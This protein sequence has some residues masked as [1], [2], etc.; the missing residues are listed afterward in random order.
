MDGPSKS[1]SASP[2]MPMFESFRSELDE[3]HD[4]R[5]RVIKASRDITAASKKII[6]S[7][8]RVRNLGQPIPPGIQKANTQYWKSIETQYES[9]SRDLQGLNTHRYGR[10][11]TGGNQ[12]FM[13]A[14]SFQHYIETQCLISY[15]EARSRVFNMN[16][17][18]ESVLLAPEDYVLGVFDM[19]GELMRFAITAMAT[20][21]VI[22]GGEAQQNKTLTGIIRSDENDRDDGA[23]SMDTDEPTSAQETPK[24][25]CRNVLADMRELRLQLERLE[26]PQGS[27]FAEDVEKK[28]SVMRQCVEKVETAL[29][30]LMIRGQERPKGWMPDL[31][32]EKRAP[33]AVESY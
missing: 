33:E 5:E 17:G 27:K 32:E 20:N 1:H 9:I 13:E 23:E 6:F 29:Y 14:L 28:M 3:H 21:G 12:E 22:P 4:R 8:Q 19:V 24:V 2:F 11:I 7:L 25:P 31:R 15:E 16:A 30:G 18:G 26:L 10:N